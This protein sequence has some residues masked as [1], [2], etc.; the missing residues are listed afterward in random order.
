MNRRFALQPLAEAG[1]TLAHHWRA[2]AADAPVFL[3]WE[4][5]DAQRATSGLGRDMYVLMDDDA[6]LA[7]LSRRR[8]MRHGFMPVRQW[9]LNETGN[10][11][12]DR[13][14]VEYNGFLQQDVA[15]DAFDWLLRHLPAA[16]ELVV[17]NALEPTVEALEV[18][19]LAAGWRPRTIK[20][21]AAPWLDLASLRASRQPFEARLG[22]NTRAAIRRARRLYEEAHGPLSLVRAGDAGE[23]QAWFARMETLHTAQWA[24]RGKDGAFADD[25][26]RAF[27]RRFLAST[28][29]RSGADILRIQAG[30]QEVGYLYNLRSPG[31]WVKAYQ[32]GFTPAPDNR[33]K[34]GYLCHALAVDHYAGEGASRYDFLAG[35][36]SYKQQMADQQVPLRSIIAF[37][38]R[39]HLV[40]DD[41]LRRGRCFMRQAALP[42][43][44]CV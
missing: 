38:P 18:A 5:L 32:S 20:K 21:T 33:W 41:C 14:A 15:L 25:R 35:L 29:S 39:L 8:V 22:R 2:Q 30:G 31:G 44:Q 23:A 10:T 11:A 40:L 37:A 24:A 36:S 28:Y 43:M 7:M 13:V 6:P 12:A 3:S 4:W 27:H 9:H 19:A 16:D 42:A 34:P 17:R 26:F 1:D